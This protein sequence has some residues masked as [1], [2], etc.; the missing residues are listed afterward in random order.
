MLKPICVRCH[1][2]FKPKKNGFT[3]T[4]GMPLHKPDG[5]R[6]QPG[7]VEPERWKAYKLWTGDLWECQSCGTQ[8]IAN[9]GAQPIAIR[10]ECDFHEQIETHGAGKFQV[11]DC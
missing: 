11:N 9:T 5:E 4:E 7:L 8:I 3:F 2:F 6:V 1:T 10:H